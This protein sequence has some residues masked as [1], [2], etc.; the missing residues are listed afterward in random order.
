[1]VKQNRIKKFFE[2]IEVFDIFSFIQCPEELSE[3]DEIQGSVNKP[4]WPLTF[5]HVN[6]SSDPLC[7]SEDFRVI[8]R[9]CSETWLPKKA[10]KC[11]YISQTKSKLYCPPGYSPVVNKKSDYVCI[12]FSKEEWSNTCRFSPDVFD[13]DD[14]RSPDFIFR[15][16]KN[17]G[18]HTVWI[19]IKRL[20]SFGPLLWTI[21][22]P[23]W[24]SRLEMS[25]KFEVTYGD[26]SKGCLVL[27]VS[28]KVEIRVEDCSAKHPHLCIVD[29]N[30]FVRG[31]CPPRYVASPVP[32]DQRCFSLVKSDEKMSWR[33]AEILCKNAR[34]DGPL[35]QNLFSGIARKRGLKEEDFCWIGGDGR[36]DSYTMAI[37]VAGELTNFNTSAKLR[38]VFCE[39]PTPKYPEPSIGLTFYENENELHL[40]VYGEEGLWRT[41]SSDQGIRCFTNANGDLIKKVDTKLIWDRRWTAKDIEPDIDFEDSV[42]LEVDIHKTVYRV[43]IIDRGPGYYVCEAHTVDGKLLTTK[44]VIAYE[45]LEGN[46]FALGL[47]IVDACWNIEKCEPTFLRIYK[48]LVKD[49]ERVTSERLVEDIR[50][51]RILDI[52]TDGN[53]TILFHVTAAQFDDED[54]GP[55]SVASAFMRSKRL[56]QLLM[57]VNPKVY[58]FVF[59]RSC[60]G[61]LKSETGKDQGLLVWPYTHVGVTAVSEEICLDESGLP[62]NRLCEGTYLHG[63]VWSNPSGNCASSLSPSSRKLFEISKLV[64]EPTASYNREIGNEVLRVIEKTEKLTSADIYFLSKIYEHQVKSSW[65]S[66]VLLEDISRVTVILDK[67][68]E[69]DRKVLVESQ[70]LNSTDILLDSLGRLLDFASVNISTEYLF[71]YDGLISIVTPHLIIYISDPNITSVTGLALVKNSTNATIEPS[72]FLD[73]NVVP[74][75][76]D[77]TIEDVAAIGEIEVATWLPRNLLDVILMNNYTTFNTSL[78]NT[79]VNGNPRIIV[80]LFYNDIVFTSKLVDRR[81][82]EVNSR[83]VSVS[84]P[85]YGVNLPFP[86]PL[87]FKTLKGTSQ[88]TKTCAFWDFDYVK[89]SPATSF[90]A[91][92]EEGCRKSGR[93]RDLSGELNVCLCSHLTHFAQLVLGYFPGPEEVGDAVSI[94]HG[95]ALEVIT[96]VGCVLSMVGVFGILITAVVFKSWRTKPGSKVLIQLTL[97][98]GLEKFTIGVLPIVDSVQ[99]PIPC[100]T[101]GA[102]LHYS[103]LAEFSWMLITAWLQFKRYVTVLGV[104]RPPRFLLKAAAFAWGVPLAIVSIVLGI[105]YRVYMPTPDSGRNFCQIS[106]IA[107]YVGLL[108]PVVT[109]ICLNVFLFVRVIYSILGTRGKEPHLEKD[110]SLVIAQV[111]IAIMLFFLLGITWI[112]GL[113]AKMGGGLI[114]SYL[115]AITAALQGLVL[116][117][118]FIICDPTT[119]NLWYSLIKAKRKFS[120]QV[121][122][123][124]S[125][126]SKTSDYRQRY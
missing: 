20:D 58:K 35:I 103:V 48:R 52:T 94:R 55:E 87:L 85:G 123:S 42:E 36:Y 125:S 104:T 93:T 124:D 106:G 31:A 74:L 71:E 78:R 97:A 33:D 28:Q 16:L 83:V 4:R 90:S 7:L 57:A 41:S 100:I 80:T 46:T 6:V 98:L 9:E 21:P 50:V 99:Y 47:E 118:F 62:V 122:P 68:M 8:D 107:Q 108:G 110:R 73:Y 11:S 86:I 25:K 29:K 113:A 60:D 44:P 13:D 32:G 18:V 37:T 39:M 84:V 111:R 19:P 96:V 119:R 53:V 51:M 121:S 49:I 115:F 63:G 26:R 70:K 56:F 24:G 116:F 79:T 54:F 81:S 69:T 95:E 14:D 61:C 88:Q 76:A 72:S 77:Y 105:D 101:V 43:D 64:G 67:V 66:E 120:N 15:Y 23:M 38:C 5:S 45:E 27:D 10:P 109:V 40:S 2:V 92:S 30:H 82:E 112:F 89:I 17:R 75:V 1:M 12:Y 126:T 22:G 91:W 34:I 102:I 65:T 3:V 59:L 117:L 114:F